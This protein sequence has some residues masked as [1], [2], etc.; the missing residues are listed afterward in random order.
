MTPARRAF[1]QTKITA[2]A[3]TVA[4]PAAQLTLDGSAE[5]LPAES[6]TAHLIVDSAA[7][8]R[9]GGQAVEDLQT[10]L[11]AAIT[12]KGGDPDRV[13]WTAEP[14]GPQIELAAVNGRTL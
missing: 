7:F 2:T 4:D 11:R 3:P 5:P 12:R 10:L 8:R 1:G 9:A 13:V 14:I 6:A